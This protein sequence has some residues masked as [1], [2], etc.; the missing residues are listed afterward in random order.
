[1]RSSRS[2][3]A[4]G[5]T[6]P[7]PGT[8]MPRRSCSCT[9]A[10]STGGSGARSSRRSPSATA[11]SRPD[12]RG[13]GWTDAPA[14]GYTVDQVLADVRALLD[15]L[16]LRRVGLVAHDFSAF[17]GF[18]LC[19]DHPERV[20]LSCLGPQPTC[21]SS[22]RCSPVSRSCGSSRLSP[23]RAGPSALPTDRLARHLLA[24]PPRRPTRS[25]MRTWWCSP[26]ASTR[27]GTLRPGR[28]TGTSSSRRL[29]VSWPR[30]RRQA[31]AAHSPDRLAHG[32]R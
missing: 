8:R 32:R 1:M 11:C 20:G 30:R 5:C 25:P 21:V 9:A 14:D 17:I 26:D 13:A 3:L 22:R 7:R 27:R 4:C 19:F 23:R 6:S 2:R 24:G 29:A 18:R 12:L 10:P 31:A 15:T 28:R 16:A